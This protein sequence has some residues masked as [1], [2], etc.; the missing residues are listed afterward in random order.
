M[1]LVFGDVWRSF[2]GLG[3]LWWIEVWLVASGFSENFMLLWEVQVSSYNFKLPQQWSPIAVKL[4]LQ[5][6][7]SSFFK[8]LA[9]ISTQRHLQASPSRDFK[10]QATTLPL[11]INISR[12]L[13]NDHRSYRSR[14]TYTGPES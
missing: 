4:Q 6:K 11:A 9:S 10:L 14:S 2:E 7:A 3:F 12:Q 13:Q 1:E 8:P 5:V